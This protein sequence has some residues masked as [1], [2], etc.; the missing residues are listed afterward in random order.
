MVPV[1]RAERE[2]EREKERDFVLVAWRT[3]KAWPPL[4]L[5]WAG[6]GDSQWAS[7]IVSQHAESIILGGAKMRTALKSVNLPFVG[8]ER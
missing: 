4:P 2:R 1:R 7:Q 5:G 6:L 3:R 8:W